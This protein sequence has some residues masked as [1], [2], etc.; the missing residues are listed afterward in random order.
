MKPAKTRRRRWLLVALT[1]ALLVVFVARLMKIQI[2]D[3]DY[4]RQQ[5]SNRTISTQVIKAV[6]GEIVDSRGRPL[7]ANRMG[8]D[9]V[10]DMAFFP[11]GRGEGIQQQNE[12]LRELIVLMEQREEKWN[13]SLPISYGA[14][15]SYESGYD[16][17]IAR[18]RKLLKVLNYA[19]AED[20]MYWL[21]ERYKLTDYPPDIARKIAGVR[22]DMEQR[23]FNMRTPYTFANDVDIATVV[24]VKERSYEFLGVD[25]VETASR[26]YP[27]GEIAPHVIGTIGAIYQ[28]EYQELKNKGYALNDVVG[29]NGIESAMESFLRGVDGKRDIITDSYG[30]VIDATESLPPVA[31]HTVRLTLDSVLQ[32]VAQESLAAQIQYLQETAPEGQGREADAGA[33]VMVEVKTGKILA[34]ANFP[35]YDLS[36][37]KQNYQMIA[38]DPLAPLVNRAMTGQYAPGSTFKPVVGLTGLREYI[39]DERDFVSCGQVYHYHNHNFT[40]LG[41]HGSVNLLN[42]LRVSCNIYFY[43]VGRR[44]GIEEIDKTAA[45]LGLGEATGVE[46]YEA[47]GQRSNPEVKLANQK[48]EWYP[49]DTLQSSIGQL[50]HM[51]TPLQLVNYAATIA[52]RGT[53]MELTLVEEILD[54]STAHVYQAFEPKVAQQLTD[55]PPEAFEAVIDGMIA[56]SR[57]GGTAPGTFGNYPITVASKTGTPETLQLPNSVFICFAPAEDPEVAIAVVIEKGW[58]G[59]TGAPVAKALFDEYFG[60]DVRAPLNNGPQRLKDARAAA[61]TPDSNMGTEA[62]A[63]AT[64]PA[65]TEDEEEEAVEA[66]TATQTTRRAS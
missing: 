59:Y 41:A 17:E 49:G 61:V 37:Y 21:T 16:D 42:A 20:A 1:L 22:Y 50:L 2:V 47:L 13:D 39:V 26:Y 51:Y 38:Q 24:Q 8:Y 36:Q 30:E 43:D 15:F 65:A 33:V 60:I 54:Y 23:G 63:F 66:I 3:A 12:I 53:R 32:Q 27:N 34:S 14:P 57:P 35:S 7:A 28:E 18:L 40:C 11:S 46:I 56:A 45:M 48:E 25:V 55:I 64:E 44:A 5:L 4:Y 19:T 62:G 10:I 29:K 6:R 52:N 31:G 58:H 9:I